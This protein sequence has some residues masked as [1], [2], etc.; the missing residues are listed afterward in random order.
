[1]F[2]ELPCCFLFHVPTNSAQ[3][4]QFLHILTKNCYFLFFFFN[5]SHLDGYKVISHCG[6]DLY[7]INDEQCCASFI[8]FMDIFISSSE[9][10]LFKSKGKLFLCSQY[11]LHQ[12]CGRFFPTPTNF[13]VLRTL[14]ECHVKKSFIYVMVYFWPL[15]S[16]HWSICLSLCHDYTI[17][18]IVA[19]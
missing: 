1:M 3:D 17:L 14:T 16:F 11:F 4:F 15:F 18:V 10:C 19:L 7:F 12:M 5:S 6:F 2:E 9:K 8:V 13:S